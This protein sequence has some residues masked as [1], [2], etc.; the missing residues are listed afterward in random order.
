VKLENLHNLPS[1]P[2][3]LRL[4]TIYVTTFRY[5]NISISQVPCEKLMPNSKQIAKGGGRVLK[6]TTAVSDRR[7]K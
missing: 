6:V 2:H 4:V 1:S 5:G 7:R 3:F